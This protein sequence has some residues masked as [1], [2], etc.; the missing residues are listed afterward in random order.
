M[1]RFEIDSVERLTC[2]VAMIMVVF[3]LTLPLHAQ[4]DS[5][6]RNV[7]EVAVARHAARG[8]FNE[9]GR[10]DLAV[11][12][13]NSRVVLLLND[14][15]DRFVQQPPIQFSDSITAFEA[16]DLDADG[17]LDLV[18]GL[19]LNGSIGVAFGDGMA[20][21][22]PV[23][24]FLAA[25]AVT[26]L[27]TGD[28][29]G[30][31][32]LDIVIADADAGDVVILAGDGMRGFARLVTLHVGS[33]VQDA[34]VA[35]VGGGASP[36]IL[37]SLGD[38][39]LVGI[40]EAVAP[41]AWPADVVRWE[42]I[43]ERV[44]SLAVDLEGDGDLDLVSI[45]Q[46]PGSIVVH[47]NDGAGGFT[48]VDEYPTLSAAD[49]LAAADFDADGALDLVV[50]HPGIERL[51]ILMGVGDGSFGPRL[52]GPLPGVSAVMTGDFDGDS[53]TDF[54]VTRGGS[55]DRVSVFLGDGSGSFTGPFSQLAG[56]DPAR[57]V[58]ADFDENGSLDLVV[59][60][61]NGIVFLAGDGAGGFAPASLIPLGVT[62]LFLVSGDFVEDGHLDLA[63]L[64]DATD[65]VILLAGDGSGQFSPAGALLLE[66][67]REYD[68]LAFADFD[69]DTHLDLAVSE[70]PRA[71]FVPSG[72]IRIFTGDGSGVFVD[73]GALLS[74]SESGGVM[75]RDFDGDTIPDL[76]IANRGP[77]SYLLL[78]GRGD[79]SFAGHRRIETTRIARHLALADFDEDGI[80]DL[81]ATG[82]EIV[83][84]LGEA[85]GGFT[86][87]ETYAPND[88][89][90]HRPRVFDGD[91]DGHLDLAAVTRRGFG[92]GDI[93][94]LRGDGDGTF[95]DIR[96]RAIGTAPDFFEL[97][98][99]TND[100]RLDFVFGD[101]IKE[102]VLVAAG[103]S[104]GDVREGEIYSTLD[105][106]HAVATA[107]LNTDGF[108]DLLLT[109]DGDSVEVA[110]GAGDGTFTRTT[111]QPV[112]GN[113]GSIAVGD[114][115]ADGALDVAVVNRGSASVSVLLGD[116][117]GGFVSRVD[118]AV[119]GGPRSLRTADFDLDGN[120]DLA[121]VSLTNDTVDLL[122]GDGAGGFPD[123]VTISGFFD[124]EAIV[125]GNFDDLADPV[126]RPDLLV[127]DP[128]RDGI[129]FVR[130]EGERAFSIA[131]S[132][133]F[134]GNNPTIVT[135]DFNGDG[136]LDVAFGYPT[137]RSF[138]YRLGSGFGTFPE[139][140][141]TELLPHYSSYMVVID[142]N[143]D[144]RSDI[145]VVGQ[146]GTELTMLL[147]NGGGNFHR[148]ASFVGR[149]GSATTPIVSDVDADRT[150]DI[151]LA[152]SAFR[153]VTVHRNLTF[154]PMRCRFGNVN[155]ALGRA[156]FDTLRV[157]DS[158][159]TTATR[160]LEIDAGD[161]LHV[162]LEP[163]PTTAIGSKYYAAAWLGLPSESTVAILPKR[164]GFGCFTPV[165]GSPEYVAPLHVANTLKPNNPGVDPPS[166]TAT[167]NPLPAVV[168][169][170]PGGTFPMG[171]TLTVQGI[172]GDGN[173]TAN[174]PVSVTN[175]VMV[176]VR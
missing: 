115:D 161:A 62:P 134:I 44:R 71:T 31:G 97:G 41:G 176:E 120:L 3:G 150:P 124:P 87:G 85:A 79:G 135:S 125:V 66:D 1:L 133:S 53:N 55:I 136:H 158:I 83:I 47:L 127:F 50:T 164:I 42:S 108:A 67:V 38:A 151:V 157:N 22:T 130:N 16:V 33:D 160:V 104:G 105:R 116:G 39:G 76:M 54:A 102:L 88:D 64:S 163:A 40:A 21:F 129:T 34:L 155:D 48:F 142:A 122:F 14:G 148:R 69:G 109:I 170:I 111:V 141:Q 36:D 138:D 95:S 28:A 6:T 18:V 132:F 37:Y 162:A 68:E 65:E 35:D 159:G 144:G 4:V 7:A 110:L 29:N 156:H 80:G 145:A 92:V 89:G 117:A 126:G 2:S 172:I 121:C 137:R 118:L 168:L 57:G 61:A 153:E 175:A 70:H 169:D 90:F 93:F 171:T 77:S 46:G 146:F 51:S 27:T 84:L 103:E 30:D 139:P 99:F 8:D 131:A 24:T 9:D 72:E 59:L 98:D 11:V 25:T 12:S 86:R 166:P 63:V 20:G 149:Q 167:G 147:G 58:A 74:S 113:P 19:V 60:D 112:G 143:V 43:R 15:A 174:Q 17:Y 173:T 128:G 152:R 101:G 107:D 114:F 23:S 100:G 94:L 165:I 49:H 45:L 26:R 82:E 106:V 13:R 10:L 81:V 5:M 78:R 91:A 96:A 140:V 123:P 56:D 75:A 154:E 52:S 119:G 32:I 73:R